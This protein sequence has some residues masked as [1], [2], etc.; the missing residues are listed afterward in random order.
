VSVLNSEVTKSSSSSSDDDRLSGSDSS[1]LEGLVDR[2][3]R[4]EKGKHLAVSLRRSGNN[5]QKG[6][7]TYDSSAEDGG[8]VGEGHVLGDG[9][10]VVGVTEKIDRMDKSAVP[11][12]FPTTRLSALTRRRTA[13][14]SHH[15]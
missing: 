13:G 15:A 2:L 9:G 6:S 5:D 4:E 12:S 11:S 14:T 7:E 8:G 1:A 3:R 10:D